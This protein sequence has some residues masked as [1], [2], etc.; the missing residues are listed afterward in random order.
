MYRSKKLLNAAR[1]IPCCMGCGRHN[2]GS[3]VMA[4]ANWSEYGKSMGMKAHDWAIA[5]LG[6]NCCHGQLDDGKE[7]TREERKEFWCRAHVKTLEWLFETG[8]VKA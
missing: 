3:V 6:T 4:H 8:R 1:D 5:A 2:D 7:M